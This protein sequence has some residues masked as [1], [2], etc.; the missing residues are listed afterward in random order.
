MANKVTTIFDGDPRRLFEVADAV[1]ARIDRINKPLVPSS[2]SPAASAQALTPIIQQQKDLTQVVKAE[3]AIQIAAQ[4]NGSKAIADATAANGARRIAQE[5]LVTKAIVDEAQKQVAAKEAAQKITISRPGDA[6]RLHGP[7][8]NIPQPNIPAPG[9]LVNAGAESLNR[10]ADLKRQD[11]LRELVELDKIG[12]KE[13][14]AKIAQNISDIKLRQGTFFKRIAIEK[15]ET[16]VVIQEA[17][18]QGAAR[19]ASFLSSRT[20]A[21]GAARGIGLSRFAVGGAS[22]IVGAAIVAGTA[23]AISEYTKGVIEAEARSNRLATASRELGISQ[24]ELESA[25]T[26]TARSFRISKDEAE[27]IITPIASL[28]GIS[29]QS[30]TQIQTAVTDLAST[31]GIDKAQLPNFLNE[32]AQGTANTALLGRNASSVFDL[33]ANSI[34]KTAD[35]LT[36]TEKVQALVNRLLSD[37]ALA[38]GNAADALSNQAAQTDALKKSADELLKTVG[39][40]ATPAAKGLIDLLTGSLGGEPQFGRFD[41]SRDF[42]QRFS[43]FT[44]KLRLTENIFGISLSGKVGDSGTPEKVYA[45][46]L[47]KTEEEVEKAHEEFRRRYFANVARV[48]ASF[49]SPDASFVN[50]ALSRIDLNAF[51]LL[52]PAAQQDLIDSVIK[53]SREVLSLQVKVYQD[54]IKRIN[55]NFAL[56]SPARSDALKGLL[57]LITGNKQ[58]IGDDTFRALSEQIKSGLEVG[59]RKGF[60]D[61][62]EAAKSN[63]PALKAL[64]SKALTLPDVSQDTRLELEKQV[65]SAIETNLTDS[66]RREIDSIKNHFSVTEALL[67]QHLEIQQ[68]SEITSVRETTELK[69]RQLNAQIA[70]DKRYFTDLLANAAPGDKGKIQQD[71]NS[72]IAAS[73]NEIRVNTINGITETIKLTREAKDALRD[74][75]TGIGARKY[76][77]IHILADGERRIERITQLTGAFS[78]QMQ[79][80]AIFASVLDTNLQAFAQGLTSRLQASNL[81]REAFDLRANVNKAGFRSSVDEFNFNYDLNKRANRAFNDAVFYGQFSLPYQSIPADKLEG[82]RSAYIEDFTRQERARRLQQDIQ[83]QFDVINTPKLSRVDINA[84]SREFTNQKIQRAFELQAFNSSEGI[85]LRNQA[86]IRATEGVDP[87]ELTQQIRDIS[88][89]AREDEAKR[90][91]DENEDAKQDRKKLLKFIE[92][93]DT[94][95]KDKGIPVNLGT[96][97]VTLVEV[98]SPKLAAS[99][100][101]SNS[102]AKKSTADAMEP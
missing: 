41:P 16:A 101:S 43:G 82:L 8:L 57:K 80:A 7:F 61:G 33:Y 52:N 15:E 49:S 25:V 45:E 56:S 96:Q 30:F 59:V 102:K 38:S 51:K 34:G 21:G 40:F 95:T 66:H 28:A 69:N 27:G 35:K 81:T 14:Q 68:A 75:Y 70:A 1:E 86:I 94:L 47:R 76:P 73:Q 89:K 4:T 93:L 72:A 58:V 60:E 50:R 92:N 83:R 23:L 39:G 78:L 97:A 20:L 32:I 84:S 37:G 74:I 9:P 18:K 42:Q 65:R 99:K 48:T 29:R 12:Q 63:L 62:I 19:Q 87:R 10:I 55:T 2:V 11:R 88:A 71:F 3:A 90:L 5:Q 13:Q 77:L 100:R 26:S 36:D 79:Q 53:D 91:L 98:T 24:T 85:A 64:L 54:E 17:A 46:D 6:D 22:G 31:R 44:N 67:K